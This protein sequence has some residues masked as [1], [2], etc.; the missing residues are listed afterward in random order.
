MTKKRTN[1]A[2]QK[3]WET[4]DAYVYVVDVK[5]YNLLYV[6]HKY[7]DNPEF[8]PSRGK[9]CWQV[10]HRDKD[11]PCPFCNIKRL[12]LN[13]NGKAIKRQYKNVFDNMTYD[14]YD[15]IIEWD[16]HRLARLEV[17]YENQNDA[18]IKQKTIKHYTGQEDVFE[19]VPYLFIILEIVN[20]KEIPVIWEIGE[21]HAQMLGYTV[22]DLIGKSMSLLLNPSALNNFNKKVKLI[23]ERGYLQFITDFRKKGTSFLSMQ[24]Y[25]KY[26]ERKDKNFIYAF[27]QDL[28]SRE[29]LLKAAIE[30]ETKYRLFSMLTSDANFIYFI[31]ENG[32]ISTEFAGGNL[33][34]LS[35]YTFEELNKMGGRDA[36]ILA[37]DLPKLQLQKEKLLENKPFSV[38]YRIKKK[39]GKI[40]W[41]D[42]I[43]FPVRDVRDN[44]VVK[45]YNSLRDI[46]AEKEA[47]ERFALREKKYRELFNLVKIMSD[48][49]ADMIWAKDMDNKFIFVNELMAKKFLNAKDTDEPIGKNVM[50]FVMRERNEHPEHKDWFTF[51]AE[52]A[53]SDEIVKEN[54]K[55]GHFKEY[56]F[57]MGKYLSF[58]VYKSPLWDDAGNMIGTVGYARDIT[59]EEHY[60]KELENSAKRFKYYLN[61]LPVAVFVTDENGRFVEI[62][63]AAEELTGLKAEKLKKM[64][65]KDFV[66]EEN[67]EKLKK[68][69]DKLRNEGEISGEDNFIMADKQKKTVFYQTMKLPDKQFLAVAIDVTKQKEVENV[70]RLNEQRYRTVFEGLP[71]IA[72]QAYDKNRQVIFWNKASVLLFGYSKEEALGKTFEELI[73]PVNKR[74]WAKQK[75]NNWLQSDELTKPGEYSRMKKNGAI[76]TVYSSFIKIVNIKGEKEFFSLDID[77]SAVK[78]AESQLK[79]T[80]KELEESNKAKD[81]ILSI[82]A[83]DLRSPFNSLLGFTELLSEQ[84]HDFSEE[85]RLNMIGLLRKNSFQAF[86]LLNNVLQWSRQQ[87][88]TIKYEPSIF[89]IKPLVKEV[90]SQLNIAAEDKNIR[91][92]DKTANSHFGYFDRGL[93]SVVLRNLISNAIKFTPQGGEINISSVNQD[94]NLWVNIED[95]GIGI[96]K[97]IL[98]KILNSKGNYTT[99]GTEGE[100]GTGFGLML[101]NDFIK[102]NKGKLKISSILGKGSMFSF[103]LPIS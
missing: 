94:K 27:C 29:D 3:V 33:L 45:V 26:V 39:N 63:S 100:K 97:N 85:E 44:K 73:I 70:L 101:C 59:L 36:I 80:L 54:K 90:V 57:V 74:E 41:F 25:A 30:N 95:N 98:E 7:K 93:I 82:V 65:V 37:D 78:Q 6:N 58:D 14:V 62:N 20:K 1:N 35:G 51:D 22:E 28:S 53:D 68:A 75:V 16:V 48:N 5:N 67:I 56:G 91:V 46:S 87:L 52:C 24:V 77:L 15:Q 86:D 13:K 12:L 55:P 84:Y 23:T 34:Q 72:V 71:N 50:F 79:Q 99:K 8:D 11:K 64:V 32:N 31:N 92:I 19:D 10:I 18:E 38:Q 60:Q 17:A 83:H 47:E 4:L 76:F 43:A 96:D 9:K 88:G 2:L 66:N 42:D 49:A 40:A 81:L 61:N 69:G 89:L 103:N 102:M 21:L